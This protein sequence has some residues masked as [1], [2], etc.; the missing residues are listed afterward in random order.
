MLKC[1]LSNAT[2]YDNRV[3]TYFAAT[4][5]EMIAVFFKLVRLLNVFQFNEKFLVFGVNHNGKTT[6]IIGNHI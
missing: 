3:K 2:S 4:H 5:Q 1:Y 6:A